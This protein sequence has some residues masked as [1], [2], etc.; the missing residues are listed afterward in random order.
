MP[1]LREFS[2]GNRHKRVI[3]SPHYFSGNSAPWF[4]RRAV[5]RSPYFTE[6]VKKATVVLVDDYCF[7]LWWLSYIHS[8]KKDQLPGEHLFHIYEYMMM[9]PEWT[10]HL[11]QR[12]VFF[13]SHTG[14]AH[15]E[16]GDVYERFLCE[17]LANSMHIVNVRASRQSFFQLSAFI[18]LDFSPR[19]TKNP[20][21]P[22]ILA[23]QEEKFS[24]T[25]PRS[26][27]RALYCHGTALVYASR[28]SPNQLDVSS[29]EVMFIVHRRS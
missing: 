14:F 18:V 4:T 10:E 13:Q 19:N 5:E 25:G 17:T 29:E 16:M 2:S 28:I 24:Q 20:C 27:I 22:Q 7:K 8:D 9:R 23:M 1:Y 15:G 6:D 12:H 11:G 21:N 3:P 26:I